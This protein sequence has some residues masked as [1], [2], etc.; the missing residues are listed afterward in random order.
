MEE[1]KTK[2]DDIVEFVQTRK[3]TTF[4]EVSRK[5]GI[6]RD[7][8]EHIANVL[9]ENGIIQVRYG[10]IS[11]YLYIEKGNSE[12]L[13]GIVPSITFFKLSKRRKKTKK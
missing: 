5:V 11:T 8:L 13:Y 12:T 7:R 1:I 10:L 4:G 6:D 3:K 2:V 9:Q